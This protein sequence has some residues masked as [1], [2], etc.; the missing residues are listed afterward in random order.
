MRIQTTFIIAAVGVVIA[1]CVT[2]LVY[3]LQIERAY[4]ESRMEERI[5]RTHALLQDALPDPLY[6]VNVD[7]LKT[8][9]GSI[10]TSPD[11]VEIELTEVDGDINIKLEREDPRPEKGLIENRIK[12]QRGN[13]TLGEV[14]T[15]FTTALMDQA[16]K[17]W[18][19]EILLFMLV[20]I[21]A[22]G[23]V[24]YI[25]TRRMTRPIVR[26][27]A[28]A[29]S[30]ADG[31]L[32]QE[33]ESVGAKELVILGRSFARMRDS[34]REKITDLA[35][36]NRM[37][38]IEIEQRREAEME[39]D[40][41]VSVVEATP[42]FIGMS[43]PQGNIIYL[44]QTART[45]TGIGDTSVE[46]MRIEKL[47]PRET[48]E[49]IFHE[50]RPVAIEKGYWT[51]EIELL[52]AN[53]RIIPMSQ[54]I[55]SHKNDRGEVV[56]M[57]TIMRD[58]TERKQIE[59]ELERR[60]EQR[61][62]EL[63]HLNLELEAFSYSVSHDLRAPLRAIFGFSQI[64]MD[65]HETSL[66]TQGKEYFNRIRNAS[67]HMAELIDGMLQLSQITRSELELE[68][69]DLSGMAN[70][71]IE[72]YRHS[73]PDREIEIDIEDNLICRAD[74]KL[75]EIVMENL[76]GNAWKYTGK[77]RNPRIDVGQAVR[78]GEEWLYVRDNGVG[79]DMIYAD[80]LFGVFQRMHRDNDFE[81][82]GIG[83]ATV[84]RIL[85]RHGGRIFCEAKP[86]EGATFYFSVS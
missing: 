47:H 40:R 60:V 1:V 41:L 78:D 65:D 3:I 4:Y 69:V 49:R 20:L 21:I 64:L 76:L 50:G 72:R 10:F 70:T 81:G 30:M 63:R 83:L 55:L 61:T 73:E 12:I 51:G 23:G 68:E 28:A 58:I 57:S 44:N 35:E 19:N 84:Q 9:L 85:H 67:Q 42:D 53:G 17:K 24:I 36:K 79:F 54:V 15:V 13:I 43:D 38:K 77:T 66:D 18:L 2:F 37:L 46:G 45:L 71:L 80:K 16:L 29:Q 8:Y 22:V 7:L 6:E 52:G 25:V 32:N 82:T 86:N 31:D 26:M 48:I 34:I 27:T 74:R 56:Y 75:M 39:R 62:K 33:I 14:R 11:M 59:E 5:S